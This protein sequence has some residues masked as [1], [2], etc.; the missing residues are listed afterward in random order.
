MIKI[1][2]SDN[3][4]MKCFSGL[5]LSKDILNDYSIELTE[6]NDYDYEFVDTNEFFKLSLPLEESI[7]SA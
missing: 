7:D 6:S 1:K 4:N 2:L 3:Q 5:I